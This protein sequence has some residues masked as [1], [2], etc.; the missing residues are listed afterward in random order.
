LDRRAEK[1]PSKEIRPLKKKPFLSLT[2][3]MH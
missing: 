1:K 3:G 2:P